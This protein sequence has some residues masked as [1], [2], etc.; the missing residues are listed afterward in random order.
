MKIVVYLSAMKTIQKQILYFLEDETNDIDNLYILKEMLDKYKIVDDRYAFKSL[1]HLLT[2]IT[3][4]HHNL[5]NN[6]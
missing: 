6:C 4:N 2:K 3:D 5:K 1:L